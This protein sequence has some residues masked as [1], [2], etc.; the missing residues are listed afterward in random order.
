MTRP[1]RRGQDGVRKLLG[2]ETDVSAFAYGRGHARMTN[3]A[4]S[5]IAI[6]GTAFVIVLVALKTILVPGVILVWALY[7]MVRPR[8][9][10]AVADS[11]VV[12]A[13]L[14][15]WN[16]APKHLIDTLPA[17][18]LRTGIRSATGNKVSVQLGGDLI[19][20]KRADFQALV[21]AVPEAPVP[22]P[23]PGALRTGA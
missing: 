6:F 21:A 3:G 16:G 22:P 5:L 4:W 12:V 7:G 11:R 14:S 18:T 17:D 15:G 9:G 19:T 23:P 10:V 2:P 20:I 8:R 1:Q 13:M